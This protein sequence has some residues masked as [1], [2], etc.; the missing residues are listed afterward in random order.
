M[1]TLQITDK[2]LYHSVGHL[3]ISHITAV[4]I[5]LIIHIFQH[6][7]LG[8]LRLNCKLQQLK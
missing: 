8:I 1:G 2:V 6:V 4:Q 5:T 7:V 3:P